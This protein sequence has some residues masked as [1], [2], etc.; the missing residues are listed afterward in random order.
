MSFVERESTVPVDFQEPTFCA[1]TKHSTS[2]GMLSLEMQEMDDRAPADCLVLLGACLVHVLK[3]QLSW[4]SHQKRWSPSRWT[5]Q[6]L[7]EALDEHFKKIVFIIIWP[8]RL[9]CSES[10]SGWS[11]HQTLDQSMKILQINP[12]LTEKRENAPF[13]AEVSKKTAFG[14]TWLE[15]SI[16]KG[17]K[18]AWCF[19]RIL[20]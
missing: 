14:T 4:W 19:R 13:P 8:E 2:K 6:K 15:K 11:F 7:V 3:R 16:Y 5:C 20:D 10:N 17:S 18:S 1:R 9:T 12:T